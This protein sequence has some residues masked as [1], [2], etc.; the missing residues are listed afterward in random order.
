MSR[1][2]PP[3]SNAKPPANFERL[4]GTNG[5]SPIKAPSFDGVPSKSSSAS[6]DR[7]ELSVTEYVVKFLDSYFCNDEGQLKDRHFQKWEVVHRAMIKWIKTFNK[8]SETERIGEVCT[9]QDFMKIRV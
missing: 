4:S 3:Q 5:T 1:L 8:K 6:D 2:S 7:T 9:F